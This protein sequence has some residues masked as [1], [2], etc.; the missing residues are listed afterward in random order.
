HTHTTRSDGTCDVQSVIDDYA[1]RGYDF[2]S[3]SDHDIYTSSEDYAA[4]NARG[5]ALIPGNEITR[6][7]PHLLHVDGDRFV[8]PQGDRQ[9]VI[10]EVVAGRGFVVVNHPDWQEGFDHCPLEQLRL[11]T[12]YTGI[13][14][15]NGLIGRLT[16]SSYALRKW[17]TLL[18]EG[19][20]VWG[21]AN[22]DSHQP[23]DVAHG[24]NV[25]YVTE[26]TPAAISKALRAGRFYAS[27]G[28]EITDIRLVC[29]SIEINT[30][31]AER[32]VALSR[33]GHRFAVAD[34][35]SITVEVPD[36]APF[37]R[38]ECWGRGEQFAWTQP[39]WVVG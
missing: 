25:A 13:E 33:W 11:W 9:A 1:A 34:S 2:L 30:S 31:N 26:R 15:Y 23:Q 24:W 29:G 38:F 36:D 12:G 37:A 20:R 10:D 17:D 27:S 3:I 28:V 5:M 7:G 32:I 22:D 19:R 21:F 16:G 4:W 8:A 18:A 35:N 14:I 39:F 6:N